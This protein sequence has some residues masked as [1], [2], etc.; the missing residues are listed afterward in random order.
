MPGSQ[1]E[2]SVGVLGTVPGASWVPSHSCQTRDL[3]P[4]QIPVPLRLMAEDN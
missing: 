1:P 4:S 2:L 3:H